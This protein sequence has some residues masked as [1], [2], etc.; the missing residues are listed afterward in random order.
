M[1]THE[2]GIFHFFS[3]MDIEMLDAFLDMPTYQ[4]LPKDT[5]IQKLEVAFRKLQ[6]AGDT[7]LNRHPGICKGG[8]GNKGSKGYA[9][10]GNQSGLQM[11]IVV[12]VK[13]GRVTD[14]FDCFGLSSSKTPKGC[15]KVFINSLFD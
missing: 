13:D 6:K 8:C 1:K 14:M 4:D 5:F 12:L 9:F 10:I 3:K 15:K 11:N 7:E 2:E